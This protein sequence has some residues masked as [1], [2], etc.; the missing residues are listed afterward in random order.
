MSDDFVVNGRRFATKELADS[1]RRAADRS[2]RAREASAKVEADLW[3]SR[4][5]DRYMA[6]PGATE[7][8]WNRDREAVI[9]EARKTAALAGEEKARTAFAARYQ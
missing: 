7:A 5:R 6:T 2:Q 9:S 3:E 8:D 4:L 1:A